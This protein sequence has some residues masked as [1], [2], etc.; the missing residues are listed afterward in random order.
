RR[1]ARRTAGGRSPRPGTA[2]P[3]R[4]TGSR[5]RRPRGGPADTGRPA[6]RPE[7]RRR[8]GPPLGDPGQGPPGTTRPLTAL[9][10]PRGFR[11]SGHPW[12]GPWTPPVFQRLVGELQHFLYLRPEAHQQGALRSGGQSRVGGP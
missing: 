7:P 11:V 12:S 6:R 1:T 4:G 5:G 9:T 3:R 10:T 2:A 8:P